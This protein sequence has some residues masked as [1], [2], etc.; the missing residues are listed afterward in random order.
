[1][2]SRGVIGFLRQQWLWLLVALTALGCGGAV[3]SILVDGPRPVALPSPGPSGPSAPITTPDG[4]AAMTSPSAPVGATEAVGASPSGWADVARGFGQTFTRTTL[5]QPAWFAAVSSWL[6]D[7]QA[8]M[9]R[10]VDVGDI[11][12][13][14]LTDVDIDDPGD[15]TRTRGV[16]TYDSGLKLDLG[17]VYTETAGGWLIASVRLAGSG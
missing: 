13:G 9:Y 2:R 15:A 6:T 4:P 10:D 14:T 8:A 3:V 1:M 17:L 11:P 5:G 16:L 7:E 12:P